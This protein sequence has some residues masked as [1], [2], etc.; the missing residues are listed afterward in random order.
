M[1]FVDVGPRNAEAFAEKALEGTWVVC[2][3]MNGCIHCMMMRPTWEA[4]KAAVKGVDGLQVADIEYGQ[5][6]MLPKTMTNIAGFPSIVVYKKGKPVKEL[7]ARS[8]D[9]MIALLKGAAPKARARSAPVVRARPAS[10]PAGKAA[11]KKNAHK[12]K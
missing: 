4:A 5:M 11:A 10:A 9:S 7:G 2:H 3:H 6:G 12:G 8:L 1:L